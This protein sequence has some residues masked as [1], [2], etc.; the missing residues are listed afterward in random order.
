MKLNLFPSRTNVDEFL[1]S[2]PEPAEARQAL[3]AMCAEE[4]SV[5]GISVNERFFV[6]DRGFVKLLN[7]RDIAWVYHQPA[8]IRCDGL[9][10]AVSMPRI[11]VCAFSGEKVYVPVFTRYGADRI[12]KHLFARLPEA[13]FGYSDQLAECWSE[14]YDNRDRWAVIAL[15]QHVPA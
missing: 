10:P 7:T 13:V 11:V 8:A 6:C 2:Q 4:E 9:I 12:M 5:C 14:R 15:L 3:Y 1:M